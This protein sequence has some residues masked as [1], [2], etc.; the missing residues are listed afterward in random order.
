MFGVERLCDFEAPVDLPK[1]FD[2]EAHSLSFI[3]DRFHLR[4]TY[5]PH[6][7]RWGDGSVLLLFDHC[8]QAGTQMNVGV[9]RSGAVVDLTLSIRFLSHVVRPIV[10]FTIK[11]KGRA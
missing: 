1:D 9:V 7:Y 10:G 6:E 2:Q 8:V 5:N 4:P 11:T 3:E